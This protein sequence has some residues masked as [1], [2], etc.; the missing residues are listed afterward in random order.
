MYETKSDV[1]LPLD[2]AAEGSGGQL[3]FVVRQGHF[4]V[5]AG[6]GLVT[7]PDRRLRRVGP[8]MVDGYSDA[9]AVGCGVGVLGHER[10]H[11]RCRLAQCICTDGPDRFTECRTRQPLHQLGQERAFG[12]ADGDDHRH[13]VIGDSTGDERAGDHS[14][15][16]GGQMNRIGQHGDEQITAA[17]FAGHDVTGRDHRPAARL[18]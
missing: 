15:G 4:E 12:L 9:W 17:V 6:E 8:G 3:D 14:A 7:D 5:S 10:G 1:D 16:I 11:N 13:R 2:L 18:A